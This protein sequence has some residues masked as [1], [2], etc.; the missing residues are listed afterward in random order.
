MF[1]KEGVFAEVTI[2][3]I[4]RETSGKENLVKQKVE[5]IRL[6]QTNQLDNA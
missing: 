4:D 6:L 2:F 3:V 5:P 1:R